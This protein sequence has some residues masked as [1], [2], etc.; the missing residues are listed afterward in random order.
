M[1]NGLFLDDLVAAAFKHCNAEKADDVFFSNQ[2]LDYSMWFRDIDINRNYIDTYIIRSNKASIEVIPNEKKTRFS[3][4]WDVSFWE[5]YEQFVRAFYSVKSTTFLGYPLNNA[6]LTF[7]KNFF[8]NSLIDY[9]QKK[10]CLHRDFCE[11]LENYRY[12]KQI[13]LLYTNEHLKDGPSHAVNFGKAY[14]L[15]HEL[16]HILYV[17]SPSVF[18]TDSR[19]FDEI[20]NWYYFNVVPEVSPE[21]GIDQD[22]LKTSVE[23]IRNN[24]GSNDYV[25]LYN[26]YHAFFELM[27]FYSENYIEPDKSFSEN[28][29][30]LYFNLKL[31]KMFES[32]IYF[33]R[34]VFRA[35]VSTRFQSIEQRSTQVYRAV[36]KCKRTVYSRDFL[37]LEVIWPRLYWAADAFPIDKEIVRESLDTK[38]FALPFSEV[39][40]PLTS[41]FTNTIIAEALKNGI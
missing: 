34:K 18:Y 39:L 7:T 20:I 2:F 38:Q 11:L 3:L 33:L 21:S 36:Q 40:Q 8:I 32:C 25:E 15:L 13:S 31:L 10:F 24:R 14:I 29:Q 19:D 6:F 28:Y 9:L 12:N 41:N 17:Y 37:A 4:I 23:I 22:L 26:D 16:E 27:T 5:F 30:S 1:D 35:V